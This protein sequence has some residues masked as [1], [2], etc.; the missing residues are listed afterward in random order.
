MGQITGLHQA[1]KETDSTKYELRNVQCNNTWKHLDTGLKAMCQELKG[2]TPNCCT[3]AQ[4]LSVRLIGNKFQFAGTHKDWTLGPWQQLM[5]CDESRF[6]LFHTDGHNRV[7]NKI[8]DSWPVWQ[9]YGLQR[10]NTDPYCRHILYQAHPVK[11][12]VREHDAL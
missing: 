11:G 8:L 4:K 5:W 12:Q 7:K 2:Q 6:S 1:K 10:V 9:C 3:A